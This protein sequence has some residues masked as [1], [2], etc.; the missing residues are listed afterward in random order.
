MESI[1]G[2]RYG[3]RV[4]LAKESSALA[5]DGSVNYARYKTQCDCGVVKIISGQN[6]RQSGCRVCR[7]KKTHCSRGHLRTP[8][9]LIGRGC[10]LCMKQWDEEHP[11]ERKKIARGYSRRYRMQKIYNLTEEQYQ[12]M[13][14]K[15]KGLCVLPSCGQPATDIDHCHERSH[16]RG[17][18]CNKHNLALGLF[19]NSP[20]LLREAAVYLETFNGK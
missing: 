5:Q 8:E 7:P 11:E 18:M 3:T 1:V 14:K 13:F 20:K 6:L 10:K 9:N 2:K 15:Q 17:L 12:E 16:T 4:V 19:G